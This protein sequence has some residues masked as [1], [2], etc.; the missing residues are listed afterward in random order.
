MIVRIFQVSIFE[1]KV[2]EF[3]R[4]FIETAIPLVKSQPGLVSLTAGLPRPDSPTEFSMVMVWENVD[5]IRA[6]SGE[7][8]QQPHI[9]PAEAELVRDRRLSHYELAPALVP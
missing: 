1:D 6:F 5:A 8:W 7:D 4:F 9:D 2:D 3:R